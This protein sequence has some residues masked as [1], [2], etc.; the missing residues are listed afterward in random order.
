MTTSPSEVAEHVA[1]VADR[2]A[3]PFDLGAMIRDGRAF[4]NCDGDPE[5]WD[6][7]N[8]AEAALVNC[9]DPIALD[10]ATSARLAKLGVAGEALTDLHVAPIC[11]DG[12][13][14]EFASN[15][16][17]AALSVWRRAIV[18]VII[19]ARDENSVAFDLVA[20][21]L[22]TGSVATWRGAASMLGE[23]NLLW[24]LGEPGMRVY[25]TVLDWLRAECDGLVILDAKRAR[26]QLAD[27]ILIVADTAFG[28]VLEAA[29]RL[30]EPQIL[31][32]RKTA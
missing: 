28:V 2:A 14:F 29:M 1:D 13:R 20:W 3:P 5:L 30:P 7:L 15:L 12:D 11:F 31:V 26:W 32:E 23:F 18:A 21:D 25:Q 4:V 24:R 8:V 9:C 22:E 19:P 17:A 10:P 27:E 16:D 6:A